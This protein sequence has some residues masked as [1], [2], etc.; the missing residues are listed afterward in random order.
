MRLFKPIKGCRV[1]TS[2]KHMT[3]PGGELLGYCEQVDGNICIFRLGAEVDRLI[4]KFRNSN[5]SEELNN[6][7]EYLT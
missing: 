5:G 3:K 7:H 2:D 6:W 1:F 4:W